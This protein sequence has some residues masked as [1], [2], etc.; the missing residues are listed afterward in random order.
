MRVKTKICIITM[1]S[2]VF[3]ILFISILFNRVIV[4]YT[5]SVE[6]S[7]LDSSFS[8]FNSLIDKE[9][10]GLLRMSADW[11]NWDDTYNFI[12]DIN[13]EEY[14]EKNLQQNSLEQLDI[15]FMILVDDNNKVLYNLSKDLSEGDI[16]LT[17]EKIKKYPEKFKNHS[18]MVDVNGRVFVIAGSDI[19]T[20]DGL[21]TPKGLLIYGKIITNGYIDYI[22]SLS[23]SK[24]EFINEWTQDK[25]IYDKIERSNDIANKYEK[26]TDI[27]GTDN[28]TI[29]LGVNR[30]EYAEA[31][32]SLRYFIIVF[33]FLSL[34]ITFFVIYIIDKTII[35]RLTKL[36]DFIDKVKDTRNTKAVLDIKGSDEIAS[37]GNSINEMLSSLDAAYSNIITA[38]ERYGLILES[39]NDGYIDYNFITKRYYFS[40]EY[41]RFFGCEKTYGVYSPLDNIPKKITTKS[42]LK[43]NEKFN[44][45]VWNDADYISE[46]YEV[47]LASGGIVWIHQ[48]GKIVKRD[49]DGR[50]IRLIS[51]LKDRTSQKKYEAELLYLSYTDTL[52]GLKNRAYIE[53]K[54][55]ELDGNPD[56]SY[57]IIIGDLNGLK[58]TNDTFGH[59]E[60]DQIIKK[61]AE[62]IKS[63]CKDVET[64]VRWGG[65]EYVILVEN[66]D[67][68]Y[69]LSLVRKIKDGFDKVEDSNYKMS[70]ALGSA[71]KVNNINCETVMNM[72]EEKM[73]RSK[74]IEKS[75]SRNSTITSLENTL[76][77]K[78]S[79]TEEHTNR[80]KVLS[81]KLGKKLGLS[82]DKL[83]ELELLGALHDIGKIGIPEHILTK[84]GKLTVEEWEVMKKHTEIGYRI[85]RATPDLSHVAFEILCHHERYDGTGYPQGIGGENIP[86]LSRI[87][88]VVDS[89][90]V[91]THKR[92]YKDA[93]DNNYAVNE[94]IRCSGTQFDPVIV[95]EFIHILNNES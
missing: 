78:N 15:S 70:I 13:R 74:L 46:E 3:L 28:I 82:M 95:E 25:V 18:G 29:S 65:D 76:Y 9:S 94:L 41:A 85:A 58:L 72:A 16:K 21:A 61:A 57:S 35:R 71:Q 84:P 37:V 44:D 79:E 39:T 22:S 30:Y 7:K 59:L 50:P 66:K 19:S 93:Y 48:I 63:V 42:A 12:N 91:M 5:N 27:T 56:S 92:A 23:K 54:F 80:I 67:Y 51:I 10:Q 45:S 89:Y 75:S 26:I 55:N 34:L 31:V 17:E 43:L 1:A 86:V 53:K 14:I 62:I 6:V 4:R 33:G 47:E 64:I 68:D 90:D 24:I 32:S 11:A 8:I 83:D 38:E 36:N 87:I 60:G 69:V 81:K 73:Y 20:S 40:T 52:T 88:S 2:V 49:L 77:E